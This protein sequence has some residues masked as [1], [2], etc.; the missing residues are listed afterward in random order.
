[1]DSM[2]KM[3]QIFI[4]KTASIDSEGRFNF[5]LVEPGDYV[6]EVLSMADMDTDIDF[7]SDTSFT[8]FMPGLLLSEKVAL[9]EGKPLELDLQL[10]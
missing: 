3:M 2:M 7:D 8:D 6:L 5:G 9:E 10:P 4:P 1:M